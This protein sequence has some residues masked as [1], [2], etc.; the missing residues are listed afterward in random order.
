M[1]QLSSTSEHHI[2]HINILKVKVQSEL[3]SELCLIKW[4]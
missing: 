2:G 1:L 3:K 4:K